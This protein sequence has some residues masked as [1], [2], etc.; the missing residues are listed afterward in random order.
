MPTGTLPPTNRYGEV[1]ATEKIEIDANGK[2][3]AILHYFDLMSLL[4][5]L[6]I[7][8]QLATPPHHPA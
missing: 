3:S 1:H 7:T 2:M 8:P 5:N 4:A 6:G